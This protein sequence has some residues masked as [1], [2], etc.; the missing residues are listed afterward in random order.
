[1]VIDWPATLGM[2]HAEL[3]IVKDVD[4]CWDCP[5]YEELR[6]H[7]AT[8]PYCNELNEYLQI[9]IFGRDSPKIPDNCPLSDTDDE[10]CHRA[11]GWTFPFSVKFGG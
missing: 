7:N 3:H 4:S 2:K 8:I 11:F 5:F 6:D 1:M 10:Y 9:P